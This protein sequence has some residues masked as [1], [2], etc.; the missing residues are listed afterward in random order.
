MRRLRAERD[1]RP[2]PSAGA[3]GGVGSQRA[4]ALEH[5]DQPQRKQ[6]GDERGRGARHHAARDLGRHAAL[7]EPHALEGGGAEDHRQ[8]D[9]AGDDVR[10]GAPEAQQARRGQR[11]AV[12][13]DAGRERERLREA[14]RER[15][16]RARLVAPA[17]LRRAVGERHRGGSGEQRDAPPA[18]ARPSRRS[19]GRS[20]RYATS[21]AGRERERQAGEVRR[22]ERAHVLAHLTAQADQQRERSAGVQRDLERLAQLRVELP[23]APAE[24]RR[25]RARGARSWRPA[26]ARWAPGSLPAPPPR[27]AGGC[28]TYGVRISDGRCGA[29]QPRRSPGPRRRR[30]SR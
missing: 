18:P 5:R 11:R 4:A 22:A 12:A 27:R 16:E 30:H 8:R 17:L 9:L 15:V 26:A 10:V 14:D 19:I 23:V 13:R 29:D 25:A 2:A 20:N 7:R 24:Q 6:R 21:A 28:A 1:Q 3:V